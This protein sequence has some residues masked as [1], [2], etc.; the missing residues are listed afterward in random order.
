MYARRG[1]LAA[2]FQQIDHMI[3]RRIPIEQRING[4]LCGIAPELVS[5]SLA[6]SPIIMRWLLA[7]HTPSARERRPYRF[8]LPGGG[9]STHHN[10]PRSKPELARALEQG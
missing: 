2:C 8:P 1:L 4:R 10:D 5:N 6:V 9:R 7:F 3:D